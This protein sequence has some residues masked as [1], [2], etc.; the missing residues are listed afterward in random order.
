MGDPIVRAP[1][2]VVG[3]T[4]RLPTARID[5]QEGGSINVDYDAS[6]GFEEPARIDLDITGLTRLTARTIADVYESFEVSLNFRGNLMQD[7]GLRITAVS[8]P[9][10]LSQERILAIIGQQDLIEALSQSVVGGRSG[11]FFSEALYSFA[12]P[13]LLGGFAEQLATSLNLDY[14]TIDYNP[15]DQAVLAA[16]LTLSEGLMLQLRRQLSEPRVGPLRYEIKLSYRLPVS[17]PN[18][19][20]IRFGIATDERVPWKI[21]IDWGRRF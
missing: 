14:V 2:T 10:G 8:D 11:D 21:T 13:S 7:E 9:P 1:L 6:A 20:R 5:I 3:G 4:F 17:D 15:F 18:L 12:F 19:S 16:G